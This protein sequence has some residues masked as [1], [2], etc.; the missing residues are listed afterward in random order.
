MFSSCDSFV[1]FRSLSFL[2]LQVLCSCSRSSVRD[3]GFT[4]GYFFP[5]FKDVL[6]QI[7]GL[8]FS[9]SLILLPRSD[10]DVILGMDWLVQ[11]K[12]NIDCP[13]RS[14]RL[15]HDSGAEIWYTCGSIAGSTQ[16]YAR[17]SGVAPLIEEVRVVCE[18][19]DV[20]PEELP[21]IPPVRAIEF[22]IEL[23]PG[24]HPISRHPYK[25]CP[26][27]LI[28]LK[29]QLVKLEEDGLIRPSTSPCGCPVSF[30]EEERWY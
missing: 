22:V 8:P 7:Q 3:V 23:E 16:L 24:T 27:E 2:R 18:F 28:E 15:T 11:Y 25:M 9:T 29:K 5:G 6:I 14:V 1:R 17:N 30:C 26:E 21:G 20:F 10:I 12:A 13:S 4:F 19:P